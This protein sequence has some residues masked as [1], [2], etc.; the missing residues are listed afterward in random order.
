MALQKVRP[1]KTN[2]PI[3]TKARHPGRVTQNTQSHAQAR[4]RN[5]NPAAGPPLD[6]QGTHTL[7][8]VGFPPRTPPLL[9]ADTKKTHGRWQLRRDHSKRVN[10]CCPW[11]ATWR[12]HRAVRPPLQRTGPRIRLQQRKGSPVPP[13]PHP[14]IPATAHPLTLLLQLSI[15]AI[16]CTSVY[17]GSYESRLS[18]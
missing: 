14:L 4:K 10:R 7:V 12:S 13:R 16:V 3:H 1:C 6:Q 2:T 9:H 8:I 17:M 15:S 11:R 5:N 18:H